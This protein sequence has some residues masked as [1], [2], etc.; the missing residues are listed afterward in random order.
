MTATLHERL[1]SA[2]S[3]VRVTHEQI[4]ANLD[5]RL[6]AAQAGVACHFDLLGEAAQVRIVVA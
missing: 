2:D 6:H 5:P 1:I 4:K 3:H